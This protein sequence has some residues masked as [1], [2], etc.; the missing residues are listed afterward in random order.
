M[1]TCSSWAF[2]LAL[3]I[4]LGACSAPPLPQSTEALDPG[5]D[6]EAWASIPA[7]PFFFGQHGEQA[8]IDYDF[9]MM[10]TLATLQQYADYLNQALADGTVRLEGDEVLGYYPGDEFHG[11]K[12]EEPV[13]AGDWLHLPVNAEGS[14]LRYEAGVFTPLPG[15]E[16]HP[17]TMVTWFGAKAYCEALGGRLPSEMEW[18]KA[19]RGADQRAYPWGDTIERNQANFYGSKDP[20]EAALGKGGDTTPVGFYNGLNYNGYQTLDAASP[21]GLYDM[22]GNVWQW[23]SDIYPGIHY[24]N[25]RGG[26]KADYGYNLRL[27]TRNN[28]RPDYASTSIGFRCAR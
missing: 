4:L 19:G 24:R 1:K 23:V 15:F 26:S 3:A 8:E 16:N 28:V 22:A 10:V 17:M 2:L 21:F 9:E 14:R 13:E 20:F 7:G 27:W 18:E 5:I 12:H 25:L 11:K 6:P